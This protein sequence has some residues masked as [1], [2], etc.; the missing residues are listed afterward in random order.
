MTDHE[1]DKPTP[2]GPMIVGSGPGTDEAVDLF[3]TLA[4]WFLKEEEMSFLGP[5]EGEISDWIAQMGA[6]PIQFEGRFFRD[7]TK[8]ATQREV[9]REAF[10]VVAD[11]REKE[12]KEIAN[13][14]GT[15]SPD[16]VQRMIAALQAGDTSGFDKARADVVEKLNH[17]IGKRIKQGGLSSLISLATRCRA[18]RAAALSAVLYKA[19]VSSVIAQARRGGRRAVLD[20]IKVDKLFLSDSCTAQV[21]RQAELGNDRRFLSQVGKALTYK[22]K[23][24]WRKA[25]QLYLYMLFDLGARLPALARLQLRLDETNLLFPKTTFWSKRQSQTVLTIWLTEI[26]SGFFRRSAR[27]S[28]VA[29]PARSGDGLIG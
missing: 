23:M 2:S 12:E 13:L 8:A 9:L 15:I 7:H 4:D 26:L 21:I 6:K 19:H 14:L 28:R 24:G 10:A 18:A 3:L 25:C 16:D 20:L 27:S 1:R 5:I 11:P 29:H 17:Q 22:P